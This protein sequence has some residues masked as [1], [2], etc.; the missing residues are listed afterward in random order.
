M[1]ILSKRYQDIP[2]PF[3][4]AYVETDIDF[5]D[6]K[7]VFRKIENRHNFTHCVSF[8]LQIKPCDDITL[9]TTIENP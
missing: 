3:F 6:D 1:I 5:F 8:F 4:K 2:I 9:I 7:T